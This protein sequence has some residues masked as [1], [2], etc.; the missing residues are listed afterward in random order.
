VRTLDATG[1]IQMDQ[2]STNG[3]GSRTWE[4]AAVAWFALLFA[5]A[6][7]VANGE[8]NQGTYLLG[9]LRMSDPEFLA[10]DWYVHTLQTHKVYN[11]MVWL[12]ATLGSIEVGLTVATLLQSLLFAFFLYH[13]ASAMWDRPL[14]PWAVTLMLFAAI[15]TEGV[16]ETY[17]LLAQFEASAVAAV[18]TIAGFAALAR[19][20]LVGTG[21][22]WGLAA[23][24]H[25][26]YAVLLAMV[27]A[28]AA[29]ALVAR[30]P[31]RQVALLLAPFAV[32]AAPNLIF[33]AVIAL[34]SGTGRVF[35][36]DEMVFPHHIMPWTSG[37]R[38]FGIFAAALSLG[39]GGWLLARPRRV[40]WE[41][42][43]VVLAL[44]SL[45]VGSLGLA[46][47]GIL[48][49]VADAWPWRFSYFSILMGLMIGAG[50]LVTRTGQWSS[51]R[52]TVGVSGLLLGAAVLT[53]Y[54]GSVL[55]IAGIAAWLL[56]LALFLSDRFRGSHPRW[57][58]WTAVAPLLL[59]TLG[60]VPVVKVGLDGSHIAIRTSEGR[61]RL[62]TWARTETAEHSVFV[63]PP[64]WSDFRLVAQRAVVVDWWAVP[65][66]PRDR[67]EWGRRMSGVT[68]MALPIT[69]L[70]A[71]QAVAAIECRG[72]VTLAEV[73]GARYFVVPQD[74]Q[75]DC[76]TVAYS[77]SRYRVYDLGGW[78]A[79]R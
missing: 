51:H 2:Q 32:L 63:I 55:W 14:L 45:V 11:G 1:R 34:A 16:G 20:R 59:I 36:I 52:L 4:I 75:L 10:A 33:S 30:R 67:L 74:R 47:L 29:P 72:A 57:R 44:L 58:L 22:A 12:L 31:K 35:A 68:G 25:A 21:I 28:L 71:H 13:G 40:V 19:K 76:G 27:L 60:F 70:Q 23:V 62:Y 50:A 66:H 42:R 49:P 46:L 48:G 64:D 6:I 26:H 73:Y 79:G 24:A 41:L 3:S 43:V 7:G 5:L 15:R 78:A 9:G 18:A 61:Q 69:R 56:P 39:F 8:V 54:M 65:R 38:L 37:V 77:D 53:R 17:M